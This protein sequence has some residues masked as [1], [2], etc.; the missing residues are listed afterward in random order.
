M[1][2]NSRDHS[3]TVPTAG[4]QVSDRLSMDEH[5]FMTTLPGPGSI[6]LPD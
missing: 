1:V 6:L 3:V 2:D 4:I 5:V